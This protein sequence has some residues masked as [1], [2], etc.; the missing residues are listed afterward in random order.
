MA[1]AVTAIG[2]GRFAMAR[3][4][5][6][7]VPELNQPLQAI[8]DMAGLLDR[9]AQEL[10]TSASRD[11]SARRLT[12]ETLRESEARVR[13]QFDTAAHGIAL[14]SPEG[15]W[16]RANP[17]LCRMLGYSEAELLTLDFQILT[18]PDDLGADLAQ[19]D[20]VLAGEIGSYQMEKRFLHKDGHIIWI[21]LSV[22]LVR[23]AEGQPLYFVSQIQDITARKRAAAALRE[24]ESQYRTLADT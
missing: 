6:G 21:L 3:G 22:A 24:N 14:V 23:S 8:G 2:E 9:R 10:K 4:M 1:D 20:A 5:T 13:G 16:L 19:V 15:R 18:H 12:E 17:A 11:V 7:G